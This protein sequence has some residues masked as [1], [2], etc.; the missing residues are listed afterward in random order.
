MEVSEKMAVPPT[1]PVSGPLVAEPDKSSSV[2][3]AA[4]EG[5]I[6]MAARSTRLG[7]IFVIVIIVIRWAVT[8]IVYARSLKA[9][10]SV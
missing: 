10:E 7:T 4:I 3:K 2:A 5:R 6:T 8:S 9:A 1:V